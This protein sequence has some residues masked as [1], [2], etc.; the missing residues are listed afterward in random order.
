M[1][2][3]VK[4]VTQ[5]HYTS[6]PDHGVPKSTESLLQLIEFVRNAY[7]PHKGPILVHCG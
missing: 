2:S 5:Y 6:W 1:S 3:E 7:Q 4:S